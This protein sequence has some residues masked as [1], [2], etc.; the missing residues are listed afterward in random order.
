MLYARNLEVVKTLQRFNYRACYQFAGG[1]GLA[2][3]VSDSLPQDA[4]QPLGAYAVFELKVAIVGR[5]TNVPHKPLADRKS[6]V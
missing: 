1:S 3:E 2:P 6:V 5:K 4:I